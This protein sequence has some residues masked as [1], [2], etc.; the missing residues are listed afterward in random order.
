M[1]PIGRRRYYGTIRA[2]R[3]PGSRKKTRDGTGRTDMDLVVFWI[4][5]GVAGA[6][7]VNLIFQSKPINSV[8][9]LVVVLFAL[10]VLYLQLSAEF[11]AA[12][13]IIIYA[14]AIMVLFLFVIM[15]LNLKRETRLP[16]GRPFQVAL[17]SGFAL[18]LLIQI[19]LITKASLDVGKVGEF[20]SESWIKVSE[21]LLDQLKRL[22]NTKGKDRLE[23]V[24]SLRFVLNVLQR[25]MIGWTQWVNNPDIMSIFS[26]ND[27][28][29]M[30]GK[31]SEFTRSF[32]KY[33]LEMTSLGVKKGLK[34]SKK[35][36]PKKKNQRTERFYV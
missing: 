9:S 13:Q 11:V 16:I 7:A 30:K 29:N 14:G 17:G 21:R 18:V 26:Q 36:T 31:L 34:T 28:E 19:F 25:S 32:I 20:L 24:R 35:V 5:A 22:E 8:L 4:A 15:L 33:D 23:L 27:L 12:L 1:T 6:A 2:G 10:A 3:G